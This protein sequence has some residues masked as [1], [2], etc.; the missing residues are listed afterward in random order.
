MNA[1]TKCSESSQM[2]LLPNFSPSK[3]HK[4][5]NETQGTRSLLREHSEEKSKRKI[6]L[7]LQ[8]LWRQ[9]LFYGYSLFKHS[10]SLIWTRRCHFSACFSSQRVRLKLNVDH[11]GRLMRFLPPT[12]LEL[13]T[14]VSDRPKHSYSASHSERKGGE[15]RG[16]GREK[17]FHWNTKQF[18]FSLS[19]SG[20]CFKDCS[21]TRWCA[22]SVTPRNKPMI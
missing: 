21:I 7:S 6:Q 18:I 22:L 10:T 1:C 19:F 16:G 12:T 14:Y 17:S 11:F 15:G 2:L 3:T 13:H 4:W 5:E 8:M 9:V 20:A